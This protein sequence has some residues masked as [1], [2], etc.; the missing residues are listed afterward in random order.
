MCTSVSTIGDILDRWV[1]R[2]PAHTALVMPGVRLSYGELGDASDRF[3]AS[4]IGLGVG[5]GDR[6]G[7]LMH[8]CLDFVL[9]LFA[10]AKV[11]A[12]S[13]PINGRFK[14]VEASYV[15]A[16]ADMKLLLVGRDADSTDYPAL[17]AEV[18][19]AMDNA[20]APGT[21]V[22]FS[23]R[24]SSFL[25]REQFAAARQD[26]PT[27][28]V[29]LRQSRVRVRDVGLIMYTSGTTAKPKG[30]RLTHEALT[31][32]TSVLVRT[33]YGLCEGEALWDPLPL[34]HTAGIGPLLGTFSVGG[35]FC[36]AGFFEPGASIEMIEAERCVAANP[37]F[38]SLWLQMIEHPRFTEADLSS[39]RVIQCIGSPQRMAQ[40][41]RALPGA[42]QVTSYGST[43]LSSTLIMGN[44]EEPEDVR[45]HTLGAVIDGMEVKIV[46]P[47]TGATR[48]PG[49]IGE[50]CVRGYSVFEGYYKDPGATAA[51]FGP[52]GFFCTGDLL[53]ADEQGRYRYCG[54]LKDMLKV[55]GENVSAVELEDFL[56]GLD[57]VRIAQVVGVPDDRY[58]EV[59]A[60][61]LELTP[62][63][64]LE[65][66]DVAAFCRGRV[67]TFKVPRYVRFV[68]EWPMS[69]T[70][71]KKHELRA[72]LA[73]ELAQAGITEAPRMT[74]RIR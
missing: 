39:I 59:P 71:I 1:D 52:D 55:G 24:H 46:D 15:I 9:A 43:E 32:T 12:I 5:P 31:R 14:S 63:A 2:T 23:D 74:S 10:T 25:T 69:G 3:A 35:T 30:C 36:H 37:A 56:L 13:V 33:R 62:G 51:A 11:G 47:E 20:S 50:L 41:A 72:K 49:E 26:I 61:F 67:A 57:G 16:H 64:S 65:E 73:D 45:F 53:V 44:P 58:D 54:R 38:D 4:L 40:F 27:A 70:K 22:C 68:T 7:I 8:N 19:P 21:V 28:E 29:K 42:V 34:F 60:A 48:V 66:A 18:L 17:V 6:V